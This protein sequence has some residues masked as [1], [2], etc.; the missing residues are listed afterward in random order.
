MFGMFV[1]SNVFTTLVILWSVS[2]TSCLIS[3]NNESYVN[4]QWSVFNY[5]LPGDEESNECRQHIQYLGQQIRNFELWA[6]K[7]YDSSAKLPSGILNGNINQFGDYYQCLSIHDTTSGIKGKYCLANIY[8]HIEPNPAN[9]KL[10]DIIDRAQS[11]NAIRSTID[12]GVGF[13]PSF[14]PMSWGFC[15]PSSC[16]S[17]DLQ[18]ILEEMVNSYK[19]AVT[20]LD[21]KI[22]VKKDACDV[23]Q[24]KII[25]SWELIIF[26]SILCLIISMAALGSFYEKYISNE[27][28]QSLLLR[29]V[30]SFSLQKNWN[31]LIKTDLQEDEISC[32]HGIR[33]IFS[34]IIYFIH[35]QT[36][37]MFVPFINRTEVV[38]A[39]T[40][41]FSMLFRAFWN[42]VDS[43]ILMS[44]LLSSYYAVKKLQ[45]GHKL[46]YIGMYIGRY[47]KFTP[48]LMV[49]VYT[50]K[51]AT[52]IIRSGPQVNRVA[53]HFANSCSKPWKTWLYVSNF[54]GVNKMCYPPSHQLLT[55]MHMYIILPLFVNILWRWQ[56]IGT[57][58]LILTAVVLSILKG[59]TIYF[60]KYDS[61]MYFGV[62]LKMLSESG[63]QLYLNPLLRLTPYIIGVVLG[64]HLRIRHRMHQKFSTEMKNLLWALALVAMY[65]SFL[66]HKEG[67]RRDYVIDPLG[68]AIYGSLQPLL[69]STAL[70]WI[71]YACHTQQ[72]DFL[73]KILSWKWFVVFTRISYPFYILQMFVIIWNVI[74][75]HYPIYV[76]AASLISLNEISVLL[77]LS[78]LSTLLFLLPLG[79][80]A[81]VLTG[82]TNKE[83]AN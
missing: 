11:Y 10:A 71:I 39:T 78:V 76:D 7:M 18:L 30:L 56:Q 51:T 60:M 41:D 14:T 74:G 59:A 43:F 72:A 24:E 61:V 31:T 3:D 37:G 82:S 54:D 29:L 80:L 64:Y 44:G 35:R 16:D 48:L 70:S 52:F 4:Q 15:I 66:G 55:D 23:L 32:V 27:Q 42:H 19:P 36:F 6:V 40:G 49:M 79:E 46:N 75:T 13:M 38:E 22:S 20:G 62:S 83:H 81:Q 12:D 77:I 69:W 26:L 5:Y 65:Y 47:I 73:N 58:F 28:P 33:F 2:H 57:Y 53:R 21:V 67:A 25:Y 34:I 17:N 68:G 8:I 63:N 50:L 45:Q 1:S 9:Q